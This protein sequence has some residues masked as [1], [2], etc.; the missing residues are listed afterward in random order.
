[1]LWANVYRVCLGLHT[2][3]P[4]STRLL[5]G[6]RFCHSSLQYMCGKL[7]C[8]TIMHVDPNFPWGMLW[9]PW[10]WCPAVLSMKEMGLLRVGLLL[11]SLG[12]QGLGFRAWDGLG[13]RV[14]RGQRN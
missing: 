3:C 2:R 10:F 9:L 14:Y 13:F 12:G 6:R 7:Y 1:M 8:M 11:G 4:L 5:F